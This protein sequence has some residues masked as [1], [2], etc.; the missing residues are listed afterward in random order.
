MREVEEKFYDDPDVAIAYSP[1]LL[2]AQ[3]DHAEHAGKNLLRFPHMLCSFLVCKRKH[4]ALTGQSWCGFHINCPT[5][6]IQNY[7][8]F[9]EYYKNQG[10]NGEERPAIDMSNP[11]KKDTPYD[12]I[13]MEMGA[14]L[15]YHLCQ[16]GRK[17][18]EL[19][20]LLY[21]HFG[22][23]SWD[24]DSGKNMRV[25]GATQDIT[26]LEKEILEHPEYS[27]LYK[28]YIKGSSYYGR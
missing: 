15:Y 16:H 27:E 23:M 21:H 2:C 24:T 7:E 18:A 8:K 9:I 22:T 3:S 17:F 5:F 26:D 12:L 19:D 20:P 13:S 25:S 10:W 11:P 6:T 14:W 1:R 28:K 4:I